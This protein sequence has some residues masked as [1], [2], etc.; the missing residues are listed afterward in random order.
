[1]KKEESFTICE[2]CLGDVEYDFHTMSTECKNSECENYEKRLYSK[3]YKING[4]HAQGS[5]IER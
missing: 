4:K 1:M 2:L 5:N 3:G